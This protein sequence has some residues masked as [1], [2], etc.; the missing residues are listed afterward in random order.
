MGSS[1]GLDSRPC[2]RGAGEDHQDVQALC[3]RPTGWAAACRWCNM[4]SPSDPILPSATSPR[5]QQEATY[6]CTAWRMGGSRFVGICDAGMAAVASVQIGHALYGASC[7]AAHMCRRSWGSW[8]Q[9][10]GRCGGCAMQAGGTPYVP[11]VWCVD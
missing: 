2:D 5:S 6:L 7:T 3:L 11:L 4:T 1:M 8:G 10:V 9:M